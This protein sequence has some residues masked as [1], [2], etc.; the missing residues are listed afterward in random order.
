MTQESVIIEFLG[1]SPQVR[2][3]D[4]LYDALPFALSRNALIRAAG[5]SH[6]AA[7]ALRRLVRQKAIMRTRSGYR[8]N[9][10]SPIIEKFTQLEFEL[11]KQGIPGGALAPEPRKR[12]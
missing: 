11:M 7:V 8:L 3:L 4:A 9:G 12:R 6:S 1:K 2:T 5:G 10:K